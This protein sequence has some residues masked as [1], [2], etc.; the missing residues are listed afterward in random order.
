MR[1]SLAPVLAGFLIAVLTG[2]E[3]ADWHIGTAR[4][5]DGDTLRIG[6]DRFR[7]KGIA[8]PER[9]TAEG[10]RARNFALAHYEGHWIACHETGEL[11]FSRYEA[12]CYTLTGQDIGAALIRAGLA[13]ASSQRK[14][15]VAPYDSLV[16]PT[17]PTDCGHGA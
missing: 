3:S 14:Y 6:R 7:L 16:P 15:H 9:E 2:R 17:H 13:C 5:T 4:I 1:F 11:T 12:F 8:A 10:A